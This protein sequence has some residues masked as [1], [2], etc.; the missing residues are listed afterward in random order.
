MHLIIFFLCNEDKNSAAE[1][2]D[3]SKKMKMQLEGGVVFAV[4]CCHHVFTS[5]AA[6]TNQTVEES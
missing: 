2:R 3:T 6:A 4:Y 5:M 1:M